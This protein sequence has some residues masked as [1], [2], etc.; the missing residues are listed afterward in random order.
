MRKSNKN[1]TEKGMKRAAKNSK[2]IREK[3]QRIKD[4][5]W[6]LASKKHWHPEVSKISVES[7]QGQDGI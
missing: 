6:L 2:R 1:L 4:L 7:G 5:I 3:E